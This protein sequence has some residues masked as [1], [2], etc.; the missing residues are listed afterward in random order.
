MKTTPPTISP[1][2]EQTL[3]KLKLG[4]I[5]APLPERII[6]AEKQKLSLEEALLLLLADEV[7]RRES[8]A[9]QRRAERAGLDPDITLD[10]WDPSAEVRYDERVLAELTSLRFVE[11]STNAVI[12][13]PVGVGKTF[14]AWCGHR[15][16]EPGCPATD[17]G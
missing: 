1:E 4:P 7:T 3:E 15:Q 12:L 16:P 6:L 5:R 8:T 14:L 2:L 9:T 17:R 11:A 13:G 10:R